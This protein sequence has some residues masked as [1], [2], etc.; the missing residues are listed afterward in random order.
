MPIKHSDGADYWSQA[1]IEA[2]IKDRLRG[3]DAELTQHANALK[4]AERRLGE[5]EPIKAQVQALT[6]A[7]EQAKAEAATHSGALARF[8]AAGTLGIADPDTIDALEFA[9]TRAMA[10]VEEAKRV[11]FD[12]YLGQIK[13]DPTLAPSYLRPVLA[14]QVAA[15]A[16][17]A[18]QV[19][20]AAVATQGQGQAATAQATQGQQAAGQAAAQAAAGQQRPSW[21]SATNGQQPVAPGARQSFAERVNGAKS[22]EDLQHIQQERR[23]A[24]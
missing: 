14:G 22:L 18:A 12:A 7:L 20:H 6:S 19:T 24:R 17:Q 21:A 9:H 4:D 13:A 3:K 8:R 1:E 11:P 23:A 10:G 16:T 5:V 2:M 15:A